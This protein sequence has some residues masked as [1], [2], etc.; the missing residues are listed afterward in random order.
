MSLENAPREDSVSRSERAWVYWFAA[1]LMLWTT[2]PFWLGFQTQGEAWV[3]TGFVFGVEDGNSYLAKMLSGA[4]GEWLFRTPYTPYPQSGAIAFLPYLLLGKLTAGPGQHIQLAI[5]YHLFRIAAGL[6]LCL[7]VYEF[8]ALFL[9]DRLYRRAG[10]L[11][12]LLG[13]GLGW[14]TLFWKAAGITPEL[15]LEFYSPESF[16][17]LSLFGIPHLVA[18]RAAL[19]RTLT[20]YLRAAAAIERGEPRQAGVAE[21]AKIGVWWLAGAIFQPLSAVITGLVIGLHLA[22]LVGGAILRRSGMGGAA[23]L[24]R[25]A[26]GAALIPAPFVLYNIWAFSSDPFLRAWTEQNIIASPPL[27]DYLWAYG[28]VLP[29]AA[30]GG[31]KL[32]REMPWIG[33]LPAAWALAAPF[34]AYL[35][36]NL[37]RRMP[38]GVWVALT[39]LAIYAFQAGRDVKRSRIALGAVIAVGLISTLFIWT[40]G[41]MAARQPGLPLFRPADEA[42]AFRWVNA[43]SFA[44]DVVLASFDTSNALP[45]W[46]HVRVLVGHGPESVGAAELWPRVQAF[47]RAETSDSQRLAL[48]NQFGVRFVLW[49]PE[50]RKLGGWQPESM[51]ILQRVFQSGEYDVYS[52]R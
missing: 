17:F 10:L 3:F 49:G 13:G 32:L 28:F 4:E 50:E 14:V 16:G 37:Q 9:K 45:A 41:W 33:W 38:E 8:M 40:G 26:A 21:A 43:H 29:W 7:A 19:L 52:A 47:Y 1:A 44:G 42:V 30:Y 20:H 2:L 6:F 46:A 31:V 36:F 24:A 25:L 34:L 11:L 23:R 15:P 39:L 35:P 18:A 22:A 48:L 5:L 12:A 27:R 51:S